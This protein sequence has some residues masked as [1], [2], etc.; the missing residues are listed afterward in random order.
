MSGQGR[1]TATSRSHPWSPRLTVS[2]R[3]QSQSQYSA[4]TIYSDIESDHNVFAFIPPPPGGAVL[5]AQPPL[6]DPLPDPLPILQEEPQPTSAL[7]PPTSEPYRRQVIPSFGRF[8]RRLTA[9]SISGT[10]PTTRSVSEEGPHPPP[11]TVDSARG[12]TTSSGGSDVF[13]YAFP[14]QDNGPRLVS[15]NEAPRGFTEDPSVPSQF[16]EKRDLR[17]DSVIF[18]A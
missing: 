13:N 16:D 8:V 7:R 4:Y 2:G 14:R 5:P 10:R 15:L 9:S 12:K 17:C 3:G 18:L 1:S 6:P 11:S